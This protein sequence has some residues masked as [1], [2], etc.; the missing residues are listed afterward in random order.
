M[1]GIVGIINLD[2]A[3]VDRDLLGR[4]T[5]FMS[6]RG[7][8]AQ[9]TWIDGNVGFGHT[10]LRTTFEA[11]TEQQPLTLDGKVWL[12]A[13]A[14]IDGRSEL[15][16]ELEGKLGRKLEIP[17]R[18]NGHAADSRVPNDAE[19]ILYSYEAWDEDCV[20]HLIGDFAFA[21]WD[22]RK[23]RLFCARDHFGVKPFYYAHVGNTFL[24]SNTLNCIRLHPQISDSL[25]EL[26]LGDFL[27]F[28]FNHELTT[29]SFADIRRL[30]P[31]HYL[32]VSQSKKYSKCY[33]RL[34]IDGKVRYRNDRDYIAHFK[35][36]L[37][38]T[39]GDRLRTSSAG[40][41][42]SGGLDSTTVAA[43]A[44][45]CLSNR[46]GSFQLHAH[47][48]FHKELFSDEENFYSGLVANSLG[49]PITYLIADDYKLYDGWDRQEIRKPEPT[50]SPLLVMAYDHLKQVEEHSRVVLTGYGVDPALRQS[51]SHGIDRLKRGEFRDLAQEIA[52][53]IF[54]RH[55]L[56]RL[57]FRGW[58]KGLYRAAIKE[59]AF[60]VWL[61]KNFV[62]RAALVDRWH[63]VNSVPK[64]V[65]PTRGKGYQ[66]L[67]DPFWPDRF[68][69][70]DPG[71]T[72][73]PCE[74]NH[75][76]FDIR[77]MNYLLAIPTVP[78]CVN[79]EL[80][81]KAMHGILP[82]LVRRRPKTVLAADPVRTR[83]Q[84]HEVSWIDSFAAT[85]ELSDY[86]N[87][88]AIPALVSEDNPD[89]V[90][91]NVRPLC[92]NLWLLN[93]NSIEPQNGDS[94]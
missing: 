15:I 12:T 39:V 55:Q 93:R 33:W 82:E 54:E 38:T 34:P 32:E 40:V 81:R 11:E 76:F 30:P 7:P 25:N 86:V 5:D 61:N 70:Y 26:A 10:M 51:H 67:T 73:V 23:R 69:S 84:Q 41:F 92:L 85:T 16:A 90:W 2:G 66:S 37:T 31:A 52:W 80:I 68:E 77:L 59:P 88:A 74:V 22:S 50:E 78:W 1:S 17:T 56:P 18:S 64:V 9:E 45:E 35:N 13:D 36:L 27:L 87:R 71:V 57:G 19:L 94:L 20:K 65:H 24:I 14:R 62:G 21:I 3:P 43:V 79:K 48:I 49:I 91:R 29:T 46:L 72:Y 8:D 28:G 83:M 44:F 58:L 63:Q 53:F 47:N 60:P 6:F 89:E 42:M 4:M 75:P